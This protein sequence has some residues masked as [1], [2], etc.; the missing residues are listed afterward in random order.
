[1]LLKLPFSVALL[2][3]FRLG[4]ILLE[5][6]LVLLKEDVLFAPS[7]F[8]VRGIFGERLLGHM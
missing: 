2:E 6:E 4:E 3:A 8:F 7:S 5:P 1:M